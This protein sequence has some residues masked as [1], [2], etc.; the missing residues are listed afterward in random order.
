[1][2]SV[3]VCELGDRVIFGLVVFFLKWVAGEFWIGLYSSGYF[4][5]IRFCLVKVV[6]VCVYR[7][8]GLKLG[9]FFGRREVGVV[10]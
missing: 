1:M 8:C 9:Y 4:G 6:G 3:G 7:S 2:F 5:R 10:V